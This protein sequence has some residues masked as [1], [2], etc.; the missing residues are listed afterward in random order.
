MKRSAILL[1]A[2]FVMGCGQTDPEIGEASE[3]IIGGAPDP[4]D[5]PIMLL[6]SYPADHSF[7]DTC[8]A[9]LISP[10]V[11]LTAAHCVDPLTH[12]GYGYGIFPDYDASAYSSANTL[13][14]KLLPV[15]EVHEHPDY[16]RDPPFKADIGVVILEQPMNREPLVINRDPLDMTIVGQPARLVGYGQTKY[17]EYNAIRHAVDSTV[18]DLPGDD[19]VK[20]GDPERRTCVGDSGGPALVEM[21]GETRIIGADSYTDFAGCLDAAYFRRT[22]MYLPF[23]DQYAPPKPPPEVVDPVPKPPPEEADCQMAPGRTNSGWSWGLMLTLGLA[24]RKKRRKT[25]LSSAWK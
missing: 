22:D 11:L 5:S 19:T 9:S 10:T 24:L 13:I 8:T 14:P 25:R 6:V 18:A 17:G 1:I 3:A 23:L 2:A 4:G 12:P 16:N 20:V 21:N 7:F 15:K